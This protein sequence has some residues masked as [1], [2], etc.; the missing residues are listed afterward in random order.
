LDPFGGSGAT[1]LVAARLGRNSIY[2]D[3]NPEYMRMSVERL[4]GETAQLDLFAAHRFEVPS[5][6]GNAGLAAAN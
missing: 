6:R 1:S 5:K 4:R 3:L 2:I